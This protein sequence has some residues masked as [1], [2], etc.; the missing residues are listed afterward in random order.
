MTRRDWL[1]DLLND[2]ET[3]RLAWVRLP[4]PGDA[5]LKLP[6]AIMHWYREDPND[7]NMYALI[8]HPDLPAVYRPEDIPTVSIAWQRQPPVSTFEYKTDKE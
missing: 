8:T 7:L 4:C 1:L 6:K 3:N 5:P 2:K